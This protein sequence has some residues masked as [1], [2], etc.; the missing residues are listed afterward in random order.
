[1]VRS[2]LEISICEHVLKVIRSEMF[3]TGAGIRFRSLKL[4]DVFEECVSL[5]KC[6][7]ETD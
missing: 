5:Y 6:K 4:S 2:K 7:S 3:I 1:M